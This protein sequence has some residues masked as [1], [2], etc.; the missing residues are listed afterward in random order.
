MITKVFTFG[1][2]HTCPYTGKKLDDH[3]ATI[4]APTE[5]DCTALMVQLF[6]NKWAFPYDSPEVAG[7]DRFGLVEHVR[8]ELAP[9]ASAPDTEQEAASC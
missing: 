9:A 2:G 6:S 3:Y 7:V 4:T 5:A 8:I 1:Y